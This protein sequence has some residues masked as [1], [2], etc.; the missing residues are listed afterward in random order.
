MLPCQ[1]HT[2]TESA[3]L[4]SQVTA[5]DNVVRKKQTIAHDSNLNNKKGRNQSKRNERIDE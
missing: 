3:A 5:C 2:Q 1:S 4:P